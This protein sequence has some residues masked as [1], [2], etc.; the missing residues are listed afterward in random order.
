MI[1]NEKENVEINEEAAKSEA[2]STRSEKKKSKK[3]EEIEALKKQ[4][5]EKQSEI[6]ALNDK[7]MRMAAEYDNFRRRSVKER[8]GVYTEAYGD[9]IAKVLPVIDNMERAA[10]YS[11]AEKVAEG[12]AMTLKSFADILEKMGITSFGEAG[13][14]FDPE[15]HNAVMHVDD[16]SLGENVIKEVFQKG[17]K[18]GDKVIRYAMVIVAN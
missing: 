8:E 17:Y 15:L 12:V 9:A 16:E 3:S 4:L 1:E 14:S 13:E 11:D 2:A 10:V 18:K 5:E 6:D 7:Y